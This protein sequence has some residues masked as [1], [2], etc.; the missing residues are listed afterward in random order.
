MTATVHDRPNSGLPKPLPL[1]G[2][3][4]LDFSRIIAGPYCAQYLADLGADVIKVERKGLGDDA[5][6]YSFPAVWEG[7]GTMYL[8][9][10]R[11]K[12]SIALDLDQDSDRGL[13]RELIGSADVLLENFRPG[14]MAR[15][16]LDYENL[17]ASHSG[18]VYC[19]I[20]GFGEDGPLAL[21]GANDLVAQA[22][23]GLMSLNQQEDGRPQ[24]VVPAMVDMFTGL[25]AAVAII[26]ALHRRSGTN[27]GTHVTTSLFECGVSMLSYFATSHFAAPEP[28]TQDLGAS[29]TV[30]NQSFLASDGWMVIACSNEAM[31][32]RLCEAIGRP[33]LRDDPRF[34]T[35]LDRTR[36]QQTLIPLLDTVFAAATRA[37]WAQR[38]EA[39]KASSSSIL[40]VGEVLSHPQ[41]ESLGMIV[42][43][44]HPDID[45]FRVLRTPFRFDSEVLTS[46]RPPPALDEHRNEIIAELRRASAS[47]QLKEQQ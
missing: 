10:N 47:S 21:A 12:R 29:I 13:A 34:A 28:A 43:L 25:N 39:A 2:V 20:S 38:L 8:S 9:F 33:E 11:G 31:W 7:T 24:K 40:S 41:T 32:Q 37:H 27:L 36:N 30:P 5:R 35:N 14:V 45:G 22:S 23:T 4:V 6:Q 16:G 17:R 19:S 26:A 3:R 42:P 15:L 44:A 1:R 46:N 18:L